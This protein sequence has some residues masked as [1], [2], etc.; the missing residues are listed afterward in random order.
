M[1]DRKGGLSRRAASGLA[2]AAKPASTSDAR[3]P[4]KKPAAAADASSS[5]TLPVTEVKDSFREV[6]ETVVFVVV[7]VLLLKSFV[8]E[9]FVIPT[10]SMAETL[11]GYQK[12]VKCPACGYEFPVNAS[13]EADP[14]QEAQR[15]PI[16]G[17]TCPNCRYHID[18]NE[19]DMKLDWRTGDR[20]LVGKFLY[21]FYVPGVGS[22][23]PRRGDVVVFKYPKQPQTNSVP[24]NY[25]KRLVGLSGDTIVVHYGKL[26]ELNGLSYDDSQALPGERWEA[27]YMHSDDERALELFRQGKALIVRKPPKEMLAI[28]RLVYDNDYQAKDLLGKKIEQ[29]WAP[30]GGAKDWFPE[31]TDQPREFHYEAEAAAGPSWLRYHN[32]I[33]VHSRHRV[34]KQLISDFMGYNTGE[35]PQDLQDRRKREEEHPEEMN[36]T[37]PPRNWVGDLMLE[38]DVKVEQPEGE[39]TLELSKGVDRFQARWDLS[40]GECTLYRNDRTGTQKLD[41]QATS[42]KRFGNYRVRFADFD[43]RLTVWVD[44][45]LPFGDGFIYTPPAERG[46]TPENDLEP[47]GIGMKGGAATVSH[48]KLWRDTYYTVNPNPSLPDTGAAIN[49]ADPSDWQLLRELKPRTFYVQPGHYLCFGD[50]SPESSDSRSWGQVPER[51]LLGRALLIYYPFNRTGRIE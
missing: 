13:R 31:K 12:N 18:F 35:T 24:M 19:R 16:V 4:G 8:A 41:T 51:L 27:Q 9:A 36:H 7:L 38:C 15:A 50:N 47:A 17:A 44:H 29:R 49:F 20:V 14:Q 10:G 26:Y 2:A 42:L 45:S 43:E 23:S 28:R 11:Y 48:I 1:A 32:L 37:D 3:Q 25:I 6:V 46:P 39:L 5:K 30:R 34:E 40:T 22:H 33:P 21:D